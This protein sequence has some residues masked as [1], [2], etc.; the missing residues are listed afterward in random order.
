MKYDKE[1]LI[2]IL[3]LIL[4]VPLTVGL[5]FVLFIL[6]FIGKYG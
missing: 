3:K 2:I 1:K 6:L 4:Y 5:L